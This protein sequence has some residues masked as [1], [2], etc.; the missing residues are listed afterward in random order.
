[1]AGVPVYSQQGR[2]GGWFLAG[3]GRID[4][5]GLSAQEARALFLLTGPRAET[6]PEVRSAL[7]K[8]VRAL[9]EPLR[10][11][12]ETAAGAVVID[13][14]GW[15]R[16]H[17]SP[18]RPP[19]LDEVEAAVVDGECLRIGYT[20][21]RG[22]QSERVVHP[23]G[24]AVKGRHW[25]LLTDTDSGHRTFR[26]DR[27]TAATRTG[28]P[29]VR[30]EGFELAEE[31][32]QIVQHVDAM[33]TP[34]VAEGT[35]MQDAAAPLRAVFGRRVEIDEPSN[36]GGRLGVRLRGASVRSVAAEVAGFGDWVRIESP[37]ELCE[38]L[39]DI[40]RQLVRRYDR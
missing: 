7:R 5:S 33:R 2:G 3:G 14:T 31:W 28:E 11:S 19:L 6:T 34:V 40:G 9:P 18:W 27:I 10:G 26:V 15:D 4:L 22:D 17:E 32:S 12:A 13:P 30:P 1:M 23:L 8:L 37:P 21:R 38:L 25:Y 35:A 16:Y 29:V 20:G 39:A 24:L 36:P